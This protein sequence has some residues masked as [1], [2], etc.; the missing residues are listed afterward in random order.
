[1]FSG[2]TLSAAE[3]RAEIDADVLPPVSQGDVYRAALERPWGIGIIDGFFESVPAVWHKEILWAMSQGVHVFGAASM[4]ALRAAELAAYGMTGVGA[5]FEAYR[6]GALTDDDE[7]AIV[8]GPADQGYR[9]MSDALVNI[10][11]TLGRARAEGVIDEAAHAAW[12]SLAKR[13]FY[14][15]RSFA[16]LLDA[17]GSLGIPPD[18]A[19][20]LRA[21]LPSGKLDVK[22]ADARAMVRAMRAARE[23]STEPKVVRVKFEHTDLWEQVG[24]R[25]G[26]RDAAGQARPE[27][28]LLDELRLL[29]PETLAELRTAALA[30][31]LAVEEAGRLGISAND[32]EAAKLAREVF[33][34]QGIGLDGLDAWIAAQD[35]SPS[36]LARMLRSELDLRRV[37]ALLEGE[38]EWALRD[39]LRIRG[40]YEGLAARAAD[41]QVVLAASGAESP[42]LADAGESREEIVAGHF[43]A[44]AEPVPADLERYA[45]SL[46]L[47]DAA[48]LL[49]VILRERWYV[50]LA[51]GGGHPVASIPAPRSTRVA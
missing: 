47:P 48:A 28:P 32:E 2:P 10:R 44:R 25:P 35:L 31:A 8:H 23:A 29:G 33:A 49:N 22:R 46:G 39:E 11:A 50:R 12:L 24:R 1:V 16:A 45:A 5:V 27:A 18:A 17:A 3:V 9:S 36:G 4:G 20:R 40:I 13:T 6:S 41:K 37:R 26:R 42:S 21:W 7:V 14:P 19:A 34:G 43:A 38:L 15:L 30:R 51:A